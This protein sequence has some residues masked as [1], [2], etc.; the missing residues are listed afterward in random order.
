MVRYETY[1][2]DVDVE[3]TVEVVRRAVGYFDDGPE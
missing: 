3:D 1:S 2:M